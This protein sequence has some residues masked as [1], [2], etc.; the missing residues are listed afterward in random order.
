VC[1]YSTYAR[2]LFCDFLQPSNFALSVFS[3]CIWCL[4][5]FSCVFFEINTYTCVYCVWIGIFIHIYM[6]YLGIFTYFCIMC[7]Y[8]RLHPS[9]I[10]FGGVVRPCFCGDISITINV[11][12]FQVRI[13]RHQSISYTYI[14]I[15]I[16]KYV[17]MYM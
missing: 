13:L 16:H 8:W 6:Y 1:A 17:Y 15:C 5:C 7:I 10:A 12:K 14:C 9:K 3:P 4:W 2:H 11:V